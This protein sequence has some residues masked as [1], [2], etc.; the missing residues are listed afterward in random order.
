[1]TVTSGFF[2]SMNGDRKYDAEQMAQ[3]F[4]GLINDGV[5][6][7]IYNKFAVSANEGMTIQ[8]DTGRGWFDHTW[9]LNDSILLLEVEAPELLFDRI[10]AVVIDVNRENNYR[11]DTIK[12]VKGTPSANPQNP[13]LVNEERHKQKPLGY[14]RVR[15]GAT[16]ITQADITNTVGTSAC[17]FVTGVVSVMDIDMLVRQ[18][19]AQWNRWY[20]TN[21]NQF[22]FDFN[23]WFLQLQTL[24]EGDVA[25]NLANE[26]LKLKNKF[27]V[28][29]TEYA[30]YET[31][32]D[33]NGNAITDSF[34]NDIEGGIIYV[35]KE[36]EVVG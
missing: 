16:E 2:N 27:K 32:D 33:S 3:L 34:G 36:R 19:Q 12:M 17:P 13:T 23:N 7:T 18:W 28:L 14:I 21:T 20:D 11:T 8:I 4:D 9:I 26:I 24:L 30:V 10:D 25:A 6:E 5:Y 22:S 1:M 31:I 35:I 29:A 15:V